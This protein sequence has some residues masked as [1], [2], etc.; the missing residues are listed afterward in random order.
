MFLARRKG[1]GGIEKQ[2]VVKR[3][4]QEL[5]RDSRFL[6]LFVREAKLSM[7]LAHKNIVPVFDFGRVGDELFLAMEYIDGCDLG[8]ALARSIKGDQPVDPL[9]AVYIAME[10]CQ[11]LDYAHRL[12]DQSGDQLAVVHRDVTP[13][14][15]L[16]SR[17]GEVKLADFGVATTETD[18]GEAGKVRGTPA[19]MAPEQ[20]RGEVVD[21]RADVFSLGLV[22]WEMLSGERA[23]RAEDS[24]GG[25][26]LAR[27][28]Q[29]PELPER[30]DARLRDIVARATAPRVDD[31]YDG[32]RELQLALDEFLLDA[33]AEQ[34][35]K[36][37]GHILAEWVQA[38]FPDEQRDEPATPAATPEGSVVTFLDDGPDRVAEALTVGGGATTMRSVAETVAETDSGE[39]S[40]AGVSSASHSGVEPRA[41]YTLLAVIAVV[42]LALTGGGIALL[43]ERGA[44]DATAVVPPDA[45]PR[46]AEATPSDASAP[47]TPTPDATVA[48]TPRRDAA[49]KRRPRP[50][51]NK[52]NGK[53]PHATTQPSSAPPDAGVV[54][55]PGTVKVSS[56]PWAAVR[57]RGRAESCRDTPCTLTLPPGRHT[58]LLRNPVANLGKQITVTVKSG[59]TVVVRETLTR[60]P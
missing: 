4:R 46:I 12:R 43:A 31:R 3:I 11:A 17:A 30:V 6:D 18:L 35:K 25:L 7:T 13:R 47:S 40:D 53:K 39:L 20:A 24:A 44:N 26:A 28:G 32:A 8:D 48:I 37:P 9:V 38:L 10:A 56:T 59:E 34:G 27:A 51:T 22:L 19:Y 14:N 15:V 50:V 55:E 60:G 1:P 29:V 58:L 23:Y 52:R 45:A 57:V 21:G 5:A 41:K 54:A 36:P 2:L 42:A 16:L 49:P 33:R